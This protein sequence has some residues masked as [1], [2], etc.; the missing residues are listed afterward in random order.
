MNTKAI[1]SK[2]GKTKLGPKEDKILTIK[3]VSG[4]NMARKA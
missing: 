4:F 3:R 2:F 1:R